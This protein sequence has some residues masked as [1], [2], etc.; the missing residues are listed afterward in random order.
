MV[1]ARV[2]GFNKPAVN[3]EQRRK[4]KQQASSSVPTGKGQTVV[5][6]STSPE[7]SPATRAKIL[8]LWEA[9]CKRSSCEFRHPPVCR[10]NKSGNRRTYG[11]YCL[12]RDADGEEKASKKSKKES[13]QGA[14]AILRQKKKVQGCVSKFRSKEVYSVESWANEI[15]RFGGTHHKILGTHVV[16]NSN[17]G[18]KGP[19]RGVIQKVN[20]MSEILARPSLRKEHLRELQDKKSVPAKQHGIWREKYFSSWPRAKRRFVLL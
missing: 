9:R 4:G 16:R 1:N 5:K 13:T 12:Y 7:A 17:S 15:E 20:L 6:S 8:C 11:N 10:D 19:S 14:V 18:K 3:N 2:S